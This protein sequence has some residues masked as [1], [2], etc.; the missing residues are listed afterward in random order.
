MQ[1]NFPLIEAELRILE[2]H[3]DELAFRNL[4]AGEALQTLPAF[5]CS[6]SLLQHAPEHFNKENSGRT[7][8]QEV[9]RVFFLSK[10]AFVLAAAG[11]RGLQ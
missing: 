3:F 11:L 4:P 9:Y 6:A 2:L 1:A 10:R 7:S 8:S 5:L